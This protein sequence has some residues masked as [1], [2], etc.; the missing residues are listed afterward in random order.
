MFPIFS[1]ANRAFPLVY[2]LRGL[3]ELAPGARSKLKVSAG[4]HFRWANL[5]QAG[6]RRSRQLLTP[7]STLFDALSSHCARGYGFNRL[8]MWLGGGAFGKRIA[9]CT[10]MFKISTVDTRSKRTLVVE[11]H[12]TGPWVDEL[13]TTCVSASQT[14]GERELV[15]DLSNLTI[16]SREGED[17]IFDL[18]KKG[19]KFSRGGILTRHMLRQLAR[20]CP[21]KL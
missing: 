1:G 20:K 19:A 12:L 13:R 5:V 21:S 7:R 11:G 17:A 16:I 2:R 9:M 4:H 3:N 6:C 14:L 10:S 15:I 8:R 18:M